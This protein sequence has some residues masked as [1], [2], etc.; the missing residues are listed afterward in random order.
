MNRFIYFFC[1]SVF[2]LSSLSAFGQGSGSIVG[3]VT[4]PS[5]AVVPGATVTATDIN[6]G[7]SR[8]AT[9]NQQG[10]Y[11]MSAMRPAQYKVTVEA[12]AFRTYSQTG[13]TLLADQTLSVNAQLVVGQTSETVEVTGQE[14][15]VDTSTSTV[16]N[17]VDQQ[18]ITELP[19][20]GRNAAELTLTTTG[21]TPSTNGGAD[22]G[23]TKTFPGAVTISVNGARQNQISYQLDGGNYVDEYTNVNQP[24]PFPDALQEFSVQTSNYTAE[25]GQNAGAVVNVVTKSGTNALHGNLFEFVRNQVFNARSWQSTTGKDQIKR[26]QFGGTIGG[27]LIKDKTFFFAGYQATRF[28]NLGS[29]ASTTVPSAVQRATATDPA[30]ISLLSHIPIGDAS[31][32]VSFAKPDHQ[33]FND[34][35]GRVDQVLGANDQLAVR[36][37]Y[38]RFAKQAIFDPTNILTYTDGSTIISQNA[39]IHETHVFSGTKV[40]SARFS[41]SRENA[42]RGPASDAFNVNALGVNLP[43]EPVNAIQQIRVNGGF[44]FG[45]NP[46]GKFIRNNFAWS[47]DFSWVRG[48]HELHFGGT[49][50][51]S[52]IDLTN[53]FFQPGEFSFPSMAA[54]LA[55]KLGTYSGNPGFRQGAGEFKNNRNIF[56]GLYVQDNFR[57]NRRLTLNLGLRWEPGNPWRENGERWSQFRL[58]G[59]MA[60]QRS[61][62]FTNAPAGLFFPGDQGF[63]KNGL[64]GSFNNFAPRVGF[65]LDVFGDG[66]TS[67]RGG[68]GI[69]YDSRM[70]GMAN[71]S[72]VDETPFSPQFIMNTNDVNPGTFSDPLCTKAATQAL[73]NC[74]NQS[75]NYIFPAS[76]PPPSSAPFA[77]GGTYLSWDPNHNWQVPT[78]YNWNLV[79]ER[80]L[81]SGFL[82]RAG[83]I[84]SRTT[85]LGETI[86]QDPFPVGGGPLRRLNII[87]SNFYPASA[88]PLYGPVQVQV[89]DTNARYNSMQIALEHRGHSMTVTGSYTLS[90]STDDVAPGQGVD[91]R[92]SGA[93]ARPWDDPLRHAFDEGPSEFD[94]THRFVGSYVIS[95]P[96]VSNKNAFIG[97]VLNG[98]QW[99]GIVTAMTGRPMTL[100]SGQNNSGTQIGQDRPDMTGSPYGQ[101]ACANVTKPCKSWL[102]PASFTTNAKGTFGNVAK[103]SLRMPGFF[104]WDMS[105]H[106]DFHF[107]ERWRMEFRAEYFNVFNHTN[108]DDE[109][110]QGMNFVKLSSPGSFGALTQSKDPRI[111]QLALKLYF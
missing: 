13:V 67:L 65:A 69:F 52:R 18:R 60:N 10:A 71:N 43:Y 95:L 54:F 92:G 34:L 77:K 28:R 31:N 103:G 75:A 110:A 108:F 46:N 48:R 8:T 26:N 97:A 2:L 68:A 98:W 101:G 17:V 105:L 3:T 58:D 39:L 32:R 86:N 38:D 82:L 96:G 62:V 1:C 61:T 109:L 4:D 91:G 50:E 16:R 102:N 104:N 83:Y 27:P 5:G 79:V 6:T 37:V 63:P 78:I 14:V 47:D 15:Q 12:P 42:T 59:L 90:R 73:Q 22:Q 89:F 72:F 7:V 11:T 64:A 57:M 99:S 107:T 55:G 51:R 80:Q 111:G 87:A 45:D 94:H 29:A 20:N 24:F 40:N 19:L 41:Y 66:K 23:T 85:H 100:L 74:T 35:I 81:P 25:F 84:G 88:Q 33:N 56:A 70:M 30:V 21:A 76:L 36:Y 106:K 44:N 9:T 53:L 93:S 49:I